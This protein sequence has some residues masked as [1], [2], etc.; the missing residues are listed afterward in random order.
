MNEQQ[1]QLL[2][3]IKSCY[4]GDFQKDGQVIL[5]KLQKHLGQ[6][7]NTELI[8][9]LEKYFEEVYPNQYISFQKVLADID[10]DDDALF[11]S[12]M[13]EFVENGDTAQAQFEMTLFIRK[14]ENEFDQYKP[15]LN[16]KQLSVFELEDLF[17]FIVQ[18]E[19]PI[20]LE[21]TERDYAGIYQAYAEILIANNEWREAAEAYQQAQLWN[22]Y[23]PEI[24]YDLAALFLKMEQYGMFYANVISGLDNSI[25]IEDLARGF[26]YLGDFYRNKRDFVVAAQM[27]H[28]SN[29]WYPNDLAELGL[30]ICLDETGKISPALK[31]EELDAFLSKYNVDE[32]PDQEAVSYLKVIGAQSLAADDEEAAYLFYSLFEDIMGDED[33]EVVAILD[34]LEAKLIHDHSYDEDH[35]HH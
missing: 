18:N 10:I 20:R 1:E 19:D 28:I 14:M 25:R 11:L 8:L 3:E 17:Q 30:Q 24:H 12:K 27:Y 31:G 33:A 32:Y 9:E 7:V 34:K 4:T 13:D 29:D 26:A 23:N 35:H 15:K 22:Q 2:A 6:D 21:P 5:P 16:V